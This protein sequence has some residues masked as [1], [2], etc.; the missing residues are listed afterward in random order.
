MADTKVSKTPSWIHQMAE[1]KLRPVMDKAAPF[2]AKFLEILNFVYPFL[3]QAYEGAW[4]LYEACKP[5][6][7][8]SLGPAFFGFFL[9]FFG[10]HFVVLIATVEAFRT[11]GWDR[12]HSHLTVIYNDIM[13]VKAASAGADKK[14]DGLDGIPDGKQISTD[15]L[16]LRKFELFLTEV[17]PTSLSGA[18]SGLNAGF[19]AMLAVLRVKFAKTIT[20]GATIGEALANNIQPFL[21]PPMND[22]FQPKYHKWVIPCIQYSCKTIGISVAF[23]IQRIISA[24]HSAI[25]GG[26]IF[27]QGILQYALFV[28]SL[29]K[30]LDK[31]N[32]GKPDIEPGSKP[33]IAISLGVSV[34]GFLFQLTCGFSL[35]FPLNILLFPFSVLEY[36]MTWFIAD[37]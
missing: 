23:F 14:E 27:T 10:G 32:D 11:C 5:Y 26:Q 9:A 2:I 8:D 35:F 31:D 15:D 24:F 29:K 28:P 36:L 30:Y 17:D 34:L 13:K 21:V 18:I 33:F 12:M 19:I 7:I 37:N 4:K 6:H 1:E 25:R 16:V 20:L 22:L 3:V